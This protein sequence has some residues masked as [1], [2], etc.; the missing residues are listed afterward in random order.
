[1]IYTMTLN[2]ALD[3]IVKI[4]DFRLGEVNRSTDE[5]IFSGGKGL[6]VSMV[7]N[8]LGIPSVALGFV[9][10]FTGEEIERGMQAQGCRTDF[11][12][13]DEGVSRINLKLR[14]GVET[15][16]NG[17]GPLVSEF[18]VSE[19]F[20]KLDKLQE[21]DI[22][23]ISGSVPDSLP[24]N[25]YERIMA[26]LQPKQV[27]IVV[28]AGRDLL[29]SAVM[30]QPFLVKPN[31]QE[32][33]QI[34]RTPLH[35]K[36]EVAVHA[37]QLQEMGGRNILVSMAGEGAVLL[38]EEGRILSSRPPEGEVVNSVGAG[39]SMVAGFLAGWLENGDVQH[40][41]RMGLA[42]GSAAA[43]SMGLPTKEDVNILK[44]YFKGAKN[45]KEFQYT[46]QDSAG[47]HARPAGQLVQLA[48]GVESSVTITKGDKSAD[49]KRI[50]SVMGL[51][52]KQGEVITVRV[53]GAD[54]ANAAAD[55]EAFLKENL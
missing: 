15:E 21:G 6:N 24:H 35:T 18:A 44:L 41:F 22:L 3:Y 31:Q 23:V 9:A 34:F 52:A 39:D 48:G 40:A 14:T 27:N 28:D 8:N 26:R 43:F 11:I 25:I 53:E 16:I 4:D 19:L 42:A 13:L 54:E 29:L 33:S 1:M 50:F 55:I 20:A 46:I 47:I 37:L 36:D 7:L 10:G 12:H 32:L 49:A 5:V 17:G 45:M 38:T 30:Y 51:A 2:P